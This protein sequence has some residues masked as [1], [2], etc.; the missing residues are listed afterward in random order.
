[1]FIGAGV[2]MTAEGFGGPPPPLH[3]SMMQKRIG[4]GIVAAGV[5][6][7]LAAAIALYATR[8]KPAEPR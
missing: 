2:L 7:V 8:Q 3:A 5:F 6:M 4:V 1:M